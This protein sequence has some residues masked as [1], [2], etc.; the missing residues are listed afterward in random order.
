[1]RVEALDIALGLYS[2]VH[3]GPPLDTEAMEQRRGLR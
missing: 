3:I 1:V 2:V